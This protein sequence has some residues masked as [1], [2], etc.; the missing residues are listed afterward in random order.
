MRFWPFRFAPVETKA[1]PVSGVDVSESWL[2][3]LFA[4][5]ARTAYAVTGSTALAVPAVQSAVSLIAGSIASLDL[6]VQR[7]EGDTWKTD[8]THPVATLLADQPND[9]QSSYELV[10]D[11]IATALCE[12]RG[13]VAWCNKV[14]GK[15]VEIVRYQPGHYEVNYSTDGRQEPAYRI[16][17][18]PKDGAD[19]IHL[20]G[21]FAK[22]P[23]S[24]AAESA[25]VAK[26][27]E[28]H[29]GGLFKR[30]ARPSGVIRT[31]KA[32]G[33]EGVKKMLGGW[34]AAHEGPDNSG[35]TAI[36]YDDAE[37][38]QLTVTSV[39]AQFLET[40]KHVILEVARCFRVPPQ[41]LFDFDR[42]T[43]S[44]AEQAGKE[45]LASLE[46]WMKPLEAALRRALFSADERKDWR[47]RFD[48]DDFSN[49]DLTARASAI[50][51]LVSSRVLNP[52]EGRAW[53]DMPPREGGDEFAN[54]N[55][56]ASQP[57]IGHNGGPPLADVAKPDPANDDEGRDAA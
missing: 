43:W 16:N 29:A 7:R 22:C 5:G 53:L 17:N 35:R 18:Q 11:L 37:W 51:S 48:R 45:W 50:S 40:W 44:N 57:G 2:S 38:Q 25:G 28:G 31:K 26:A 15:T 20:R 13:A 54:P 9:W 21:P 3:D 10:R 30:G 24:L 39:D 6:Q 33:D 23:L 27:L 56:G 47:V 12:D 1:A 4:G 41:L 32:V 46:F 8:A 19:I 42:A 34:K 36:L 55:T 52:N 49:V 14:G